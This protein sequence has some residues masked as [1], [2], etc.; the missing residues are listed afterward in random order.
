MDYSRYKKLMKNMAENLEGYL[1]TIDS[2]A[3]IQGITDE[4]YE[5]ARKKVEKLIKHLKKG[6]GEKVFDEDRFRELLASG[7]LDEV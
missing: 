7:K 3:I 2:Y 5:D 4:E 1:N 6:H